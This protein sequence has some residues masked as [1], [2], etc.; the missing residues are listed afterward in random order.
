[1]ASINVEL[2]YFEHR[3]TKRLIGLLGR[4]AEV[5]PIRLWAYC[6]RN[7]RETGEL[8]GYSPEEIEALVGWWGVRG[9]MLPALVAT[10]WVEETAAG[11][12][13]HE[14]EEYQGHIEAYRKKAAAAARQRWSKGPELPHH[15]PS[16]PASNAP[17]IAVGNASAVIAVPATLSPS[18]Q[19][20]EE[21]APEL[22]HAFAEIPTEAEFCGECSKL[23]VPVWFSRRKFAMEDE[24]PM[25]W[26][27]CD[28]R[29]RVR[30]VFCWWEEDGRPTDPPRRRAAASGAPTESVWEIKTKLEAVE[31]EITTIKGRGHDGPLRLELQ[32]KDKP[33]FQELTARRAE[34]KKRLTA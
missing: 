21:P 26:R 9:A 1:M 20:K 32:E 10:G 6:G 27:S 17:S 18:P 33:R 15:A 12:K 30:A 24:K 23:G 7:H 4:G 28:W 16:I 19:R 22:Q 3:K 14:W 5:I 2:D 11:W 29:K 8:A 13:M 31:A 34:L 25:A